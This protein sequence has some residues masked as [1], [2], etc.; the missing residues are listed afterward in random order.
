M[1]QGGF[2]C[3]LEGAREIIREAGKRTGYRL[4]D[5]LHLRQLHGMENTWQVGE[6]A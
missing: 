6:D 4:V 2:E 5:L 3:P 1:G